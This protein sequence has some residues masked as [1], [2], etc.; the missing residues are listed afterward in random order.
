MRS[1]SCNKYLVNVSKN[2]KLSPKY[3][4][5]SLHKCFLK[6]GCDFYSML[7]NFSLVVSAVSGLKSESRSLLS[8]SHPHISLKCC[9]INCWIVNFSI[10]L[11]CVI[12]GESSYSFRTLYL[13]WNIL[14]PYYRKII[15]AKGEESAAWWTKRTCL[16]PPQIPK[17]IPYLLILHH[18]TP[19]RRR[20]A[21]NPA[22]FHHSLQVP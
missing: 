13:F 22:K 20:F 15:Y 4:F 6:S 14:H 9:Q 8:S 19:V 16:I 2:S 21:Q 17:W 3:E 1:N 5:L 10:K 18:A 11:N 7:S 12:L